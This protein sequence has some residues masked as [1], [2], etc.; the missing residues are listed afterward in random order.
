MFGVDNVESVSLTIEVD[1]VGSDKIYYLLKAPNALQVIAGY[2]TSLASQN[3]GTAGLIQIENWG[4]AGTAIKAGA[5]GTVIPALGGT[6][7]AAR[8]TAN[9]PA[10]GTV[11]ADGDNI[12]EGEWLVARWTEEGTGW[13][14][15]DRFHYLLQYVNGVYNA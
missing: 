9:T 3:A 2:M 10:A 5:A 7:S 13:V 11:S 6:A 12:A 15:A 1:P 4:T 14:A 8:L